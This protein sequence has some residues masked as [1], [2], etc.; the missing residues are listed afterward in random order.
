MV[1][2]ALSMPPL[3]FVKSWYVILVLKGVNKT[4]YI[5]NK[6]NVGNSYISFI[7][8]HFT[9]KIPMITTMASHDL[10]LHLLPLLTALFAII[11]ASDISIKTTTIYPFPC[12]TLIRTCNASLYHNGKG[13]PKETIAS[14]YFVN[15]SQRQ[16]FRYSYQY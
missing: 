11:L 14:F 12:S 1:G 8:H 7:L 15:S 4:F 6:Y 3:L 10:L 16:D 13:D 9:R 2:L 5:E